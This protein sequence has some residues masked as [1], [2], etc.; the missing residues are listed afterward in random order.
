MLNSERFAFDLPE[1]EPSVIAHERDDGIEL[2]VYELSVVSDDR[3]PDTSAGLTVLVIDLRDRDVE[4]ALEPPDQTLDDTSFALE[5]GYPL[6]RQLSCHY[7]DYHSRS[8]ILDAR[9]WML[10]TRYWMLDTR[11]KSST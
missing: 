9:Y 8:S 11:Y 5:R 10:D 1:V 4:P 6:Q 7:A 3:Y 2:L